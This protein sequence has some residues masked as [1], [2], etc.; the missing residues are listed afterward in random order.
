MTRLILV[1]LLFLVTTGIATGQS[2]PDR[3]RSLRV[4]DVSWVV[5]EQYLDSST[6]VVIPLGAEA[7]EHGPQLTLRNDQLLAQYYADRVFA[8]TPVA[9]YPTI[10]Y[11]YYPAFV[12]YPGS[13]TLRLETARDLVIDIVRS[14]ARHG[15]RRF[16]IL[17]TGVSTVRALQ[18][19]QDS[20][21]AS[22]ILMRFTNGGARTRAA[23]ARLRQQPGGTHADEFE[24]S[25][26]LYMYPDRVDMS[27]AAK[28]YHPGQSPL[29][30]D[31]ATAAREGRTWSRT[32]IYGDAT[33]AT[34]EKGRIVVEAH[35]ADILEEI[36]A[37]RRMPLPPR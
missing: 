15:P 11:H 35:V 5:A 31:S 8:A 7:K 14:I 34:R 32:G 33:L 22:G 2:A 19:A 4:A 30:R 9:M 20:L 21:A 23:E 3:S 16:Y 17:N 24:T 13:T 29:A 18:P 26:M 10:T 36:A 12:E 27:K 1:L 6:V 28:D 25:M 37:L